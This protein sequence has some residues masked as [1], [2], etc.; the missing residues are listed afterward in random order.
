MRK[1][2]GLTL[3]EL[4]VTI[5]I[6]GVLVGVALPA[7]KGHMSSTRR[8]TAT[9]CLMEYAQFMERIFS[10]NMTYQTDN[11]VPLTQLPA[12]NCSRDLNGLY[13]FTMAPPQVAA[14]ALTATPTGAQYGDACGTLTLD[15]MGVRT[16]RGAGDAATIR[17]C[18]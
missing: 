16:A 4:M 14:F 2:Q 10:A 1:Q 18:W 8:A 3:M 11:G 15:N 17:A 9:A 7:Y 6:L 5:T 12:T 13:T